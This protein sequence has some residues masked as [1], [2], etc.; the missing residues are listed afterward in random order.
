QQEERIR[1]HSLSSSIIQSSSPATSLDVHQA[2]QIIISSE[3]E[4]ILYGDQLRRTSSYTRST[5]QSRHERKRAEG[6]LR[7]SRV[8]TSHHQGSQIL[9]HLPVHA[10]GRR[11]LR[12]RRPNRY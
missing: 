1:L 4:R 2:L 7:P 5:R 11:V 3:R 8:E 10:R 9:R 12:V 6:R